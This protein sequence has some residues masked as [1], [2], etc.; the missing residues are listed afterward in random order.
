MIFF[1]SGHRADK[2]YFPQ[3]SLRWSKCD[4]HISHILG[5]D[6]FQRFIT[7]IFYFQSISD[8]GGQSKMTVQ[9]RY[10]A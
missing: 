3:K 9:I 4:F 1:A 6:D 8:T 5:Y 7:H 2:N 10:G